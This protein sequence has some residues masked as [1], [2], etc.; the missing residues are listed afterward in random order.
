[1]TYAL[2][3]SHKPRC[4]EADCGDVPEKPYTGSPASEYPPFQPCLSHDFCSAL[5]G[6]GHE[7]IA[8]SHTNRTTLDLL[9]QLRQLVRNAGRSDIRSV[10]TLIGKVIGNQIAG[11]MCVRLLYWFP[12][13]TKRAVGSTSPGATGT[14][15]AICLKVRSTGA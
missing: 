14:P 1:M 7:P 11:I 9:A 3:P 13:A 12:R 5:P 15:S 4:W 8:E 10:P 6:D 2:L